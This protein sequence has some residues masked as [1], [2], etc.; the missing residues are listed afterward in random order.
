MKMKRLGRC[1]QTK[2]TLISTVV[3]VAICALAMVTASVAQTAPAATNTS[4]TLPKDS[5]LQV[6]FK[7]PS[8][9]APKPGVP[10]AFNL[11]S[12]KAVTVPANFT[13]A[14][15]MKMDTGL[16]P[17]SETNGN[18]SSTVAGGNPPYSFQLD[19]GSFPPLGMHLG[20]NG[21]LYGTPAPP[22]LGGYKP[23]SVCA[24]D[25]S[26]TA[27]C[28]QVPLSTPPVVHPN[29]LILGAA[30][31]GGAIAVGAVA[32]ES[33]SKSSTSSSSGNCSSLTQN[34]NNLAGECLDD[35][36][37]TACTQVNSACNQMCQCLGLGT[38]NTETGS[39]Q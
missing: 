35:N 11:C 23:F 22:T 14:D 37:Q 10:T 9:P 12:G 7:A 39:C 24:V 19:S 26:A 15:G 36:N 32:A 33:L 2:V 21:L 13:D 18:M 20:L 16:Q 34:C 8:I 30:V 3:L 17:C 4:A 29:H 5:K 6:K 25:M 1:L 28:H 31:A 38:F 27:D